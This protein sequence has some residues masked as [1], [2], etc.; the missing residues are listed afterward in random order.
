MK[1]VLMFFY[2][3]YG[4]LSF[5]FL[6]IFMLPGYLVVKL[7]MPYSKQIKGVYA[8]NRV[9]IF[10]WAAITGMRFNITG[11][12]HIDPNQSYVVVSNHL[13]ALDIH[14]VSYGCRA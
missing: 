2:S 11:K 5:L 14:A 6:N 9:G 4:I 7:T 13:N 1:K 8:V 10:I 12:E 3:I